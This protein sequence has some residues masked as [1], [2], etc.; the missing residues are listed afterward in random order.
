MTTNDRHNGKPPPGQRKQRAGQFK[1]GK[2]P[3]RFAYAKGH[4]PRRHQLTQEER[5]RGGRTSAKKQ[6]FTYWQGQF[7]Y[8]QESLFE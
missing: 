8:S 3:R 5:R 4:D 6:F 7:F 1:K 2:D